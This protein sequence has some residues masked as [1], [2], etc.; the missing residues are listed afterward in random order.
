VAGSGVQL[1]QVVTINRVRRLCERWTDLLLGQLAEVCPVERFSHN[2]QRVEQFARDAKGCREPEIAWSVLHAS[3]RMSVRGL[4]TGEAANS[5]LNR[6]VAA[7][8]LAN[9]PAGLFASTGIPKDLWVTRMERNSN[10]ARVL[11]DQL[12]ASDTTG[13]EGIGA[14]VLRRG[15]HP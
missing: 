14:R 15:R 1:S 3:L 6:Q 2:Q 5:D 8:V 9:L 12:L 13:V 10:D 11:V 4:L 7:G